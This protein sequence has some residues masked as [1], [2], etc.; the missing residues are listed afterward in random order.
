MK[1]SNDDVY[2]SKYTVTSCSVWNI[3]MT[4]I[5]QIYKTSFYLMEYSGEDFHFSNYTEPIV[6]SWSITAMTFSANTQGPLLLV[7]EYSGDGFH[8]VNTQSRCGE[9]Y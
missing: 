3:V 9:Q 4:F 8:P 5:Q 2:F 1:D 6:C 7:M